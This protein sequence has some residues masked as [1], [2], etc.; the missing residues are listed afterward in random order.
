M[1]FQILVLT[2][3][4]K[5]EANQDSWLRNIFH[6]RVEYQGWPLNLIIDSSSSMNVLFQE[7]MNKLQRLVEK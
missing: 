1:E 7:I 3:Q 5:N 2:S 6:T 4:K